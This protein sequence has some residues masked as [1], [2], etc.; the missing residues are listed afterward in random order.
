MQAARKYIDATAREVDDDD[1]DD[2]L[3][4]DDDESDDEDEDDD[5]M[6]SVGK[7]EYGQSLSIYRQF[8]D[9]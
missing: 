3:I 8:H 9:R 6:L 2:D 1:D 7:N 4:D 5:S